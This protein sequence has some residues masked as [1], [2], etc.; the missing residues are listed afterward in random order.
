MR[1]RKRFFFFV[2]LPITLFFMHVLMTARPPSRLPSLLRHSQSTLGC[3]LS[4]NAVEFFTVCVGVPAKRR[5]LPSRLP[6]FFFN[7]SN[8][9]IGIH[10][11]T[12]THTQMPVLCV[13]IPGN[14]SE[15]S[16]LCICSKPRTPPPAAVQLGS[17]DKQ[18]EMRELLRTRP[19]P[20]ISALATHTMRSV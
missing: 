2:L 7:L 8:T 5:R 17:A 11:H 14:Q 4:P 9:S 15:G 20:P 19:A 6:S 13:Y 1:A 18:L 3:C 10:T 16:A 12:R